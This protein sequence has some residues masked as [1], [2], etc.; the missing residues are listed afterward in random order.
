MKRNKVYFLDT[1]SLRFSSLKAI[2]T[3]AFLLC[4]TVSLR[5]QDPIPSCPL[6]G[7]VTADCDTLRSYS[8]R[9]DTVSIP[10][11][12]FPTAFR[13]S[14]ANELTDSLGILNPF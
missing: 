14:G 8:Q 13:Q 4:C 10:Q 7:K 2:F 11:I 3:V 1:A 6:L 12:A 5:A 9:T